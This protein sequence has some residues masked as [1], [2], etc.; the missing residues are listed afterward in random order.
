MSVCELRFAFKTRSHIAVDTLNNTRNDTQDA[1]KTQ[2]K[3]QEG[4]INDTQNNT[5]DTTKTQEKTQ[6]GL[7]YAKNQLQIT[8]ANHLLNDKSSIVAEGDIYFVRLLY[9]LI[10]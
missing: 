2:E 1:T 7:I 8:A 5:Q 6:G 3:T 4:L 9:L 10:A